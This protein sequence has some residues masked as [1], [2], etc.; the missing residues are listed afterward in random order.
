VG[1]VQNNWVDNDA[2]LDAPRQQHWVLSSRAH[3]VF[4]VD[5]FAFSVGAIRVEEANTFDVPGTS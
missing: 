1:S 4:D 5:A 2:L 3:I